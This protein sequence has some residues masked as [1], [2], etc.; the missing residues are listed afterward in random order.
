MNK[1][2]LLEQKISTLEIILEA[3]IDELIDQ[4]LL[5]Q[6]ELDSKI[7]TKIKHLN[8]QIEKE[9]EEIEII[10]FPYWGEKGEA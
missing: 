6:L 10:D 8:N 4:E 2:Y 9:K 1:I 5:D 3:L 7:L